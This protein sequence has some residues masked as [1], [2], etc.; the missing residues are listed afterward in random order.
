MATRQMDRTPPHAGG[1]PF[2]RTRAE[3][4]DRATRNA[5][6][7]SQRGRIIEGAAEAASE[8]GYAAT[9]VAD[10]VARARVSR[11]TF[12]EHFATKDEC[13]VAVID[14]AAMALN[15]QIADAAKLASPE[16]PGAAVDAMID[17]FCTAI[18][19]Q[20][21]FARVFFCEA[22]AAGDSPRAARD[23]GIER[24]VA[25]IR[26]Q[27]VQLQAANPELVSLG[28]TQLQILIDGIAEHTRRLLDH[29]RLADLPRFA[30]DF[31]AACRRMLALD[32]GPPEV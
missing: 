4:R 1:L 28:D 23:T 21:E 18:V 26:R 20:S 24:V 15:A 32:P 22:L 7:A 8:N 9:T 27:L 10:I 25:Q 16:D 3:E 30:P 31:A 2:T 19:T 11:T 17:A 13:L 29:G 14:L 5:V 6:L 12:Y